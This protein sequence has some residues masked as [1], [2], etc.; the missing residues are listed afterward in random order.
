LNSKPNLRQSLIWGAV[1]LSCCGAGCAVGPDFHRPAPPPEAGYTT[2]PLPDV[3]ASAADIPGGDP[4]RFVMGRDIPSAWWT[5][6]GSDKLNALVQKALADNPTLP[7]AQAALRQAQELTKAQRAA[8][9]PTIT[10]SF[11]ATRQ[12][13]AG[14]L[15][16]NY[17]GQQGDG[18]VIQ[19]A[20][21]TQPVAYNF[22]T[23]Q[24]GLTYTLDVFGQNR[25]QVESLKAQA[26]TLRY[27]M[28]ATYIT[29]IGN[30]V[31]AAVQEASLEAQIKATNAYVAE[32][33]KTSRIVHAQRDEGYAD[34]L[35]VAQ[36]DTALA[37]AKALL[38]PL[39]KALEQTHD[40][41]RA[42]VGVF[43]NQPLDDSID[44]ASLHL[45]AELPVSL[46]A[47]LI[48]QR[49]DVRAAE[50]LV[51]AASADVGVAAANRLPQ[52]NV[53]GAY[54]GAASAVD[55]LFAPGGPFWSLAGDVSATAFDG[56]ALRH[57]QRAAEQALLQAKAQ[58][59]QA[60][61]TAFQNVA[62]TLHAI[63]TDAEALV[64]AGQAER[65]AGVARDVTLVQ[66]QA[67][68]VNEQTFL[69]AEAAYQQALV[70]RVQAQASRLTDA[71]ALYQALGGDWTGAA[72]ATNR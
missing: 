64:A 22:Y 5:V 13:I 41:V 61:L 66:R 2:K 21:P 46:P 47:R 55:Q 34:A 9:W 27:Q 45:P 49:P 24:V 11:D 36:Q 60:L 26:E 38:P 67:G 15:S 71:A 6:F 62:D 29:L 3:T 8:F 42:L 20:S 52:F 4:E 39:R 43:P 63:D 68:Y 12:Q 28:Q 33:E 51:H 19:P 17:P 37:Q 18:S 57:R 59:R 72:T 48:D 70:V 44:L 54:G 53:T 1:L 23:A 35:D 40:L 30:V 69:T 65:Q 14:N 32:L 58:Y 10:P 31:G 56:G 16:S 7:A 25:R 50:A